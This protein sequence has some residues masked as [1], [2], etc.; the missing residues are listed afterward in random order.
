MALAY[1]QICGETV[2]GSLLIS[3]SQTSGEKQANLSQLGEAALVHLAQRHGANAEQ[4]LRCAGLLSS[5]L[6]LLHFRLP[7]ADIPTLDNWRAEQVDAIT[8]VEFDSLM[9]QIT[10]KPL[11]VKTHEEETK[12][13]DEAG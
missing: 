12:V 8:R 7:I 2:V 9:S 1:C 6:A 10:L 3:T 13:S 11:P 4:V 5:L